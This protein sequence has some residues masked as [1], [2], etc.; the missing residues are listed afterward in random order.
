MA[1]L[2]EGMFSESFIGS[3][4]PAC[5]AMSTFS[6]ILG[7]LVGVVL[8]GEGGERFSTTVNG[9]LLPRDESGSSI[10]LHEHSLPLD[11]SQ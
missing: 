2:E 7:N 6:E 1:L 5:E 3:L 10:A 4:L 9:V 11:G 8:T